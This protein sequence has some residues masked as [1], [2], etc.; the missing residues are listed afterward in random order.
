MEKKFYIGQPLI[1]KDTG[2]KVTFAYDNDEEETPC[3]V[4]K[5]DNYFS[6]EYYDYADLEPAT[7]F[8]FSELIAGL[9][10]GCFEAGTEFRAPSTDSVITVVQGF[11]G[12]YLDR[13]RLN[14]RVF[15]ISIDIHSTWTLVGDG[16]EMTLE[17]IEAEQ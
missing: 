15:P 14:G 2:E 10:Q 7:E 8:K 3:I 4:L 9:E 16:K 6:H 11:H 1:I 13:S 5:T 17:E 12:L